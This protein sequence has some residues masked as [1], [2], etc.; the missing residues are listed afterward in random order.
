MFIIYSKPNCAYCVQA[1]NL[2]KSKGLEYLELMLDLGQPKQ[3]DT[4]YVF[5]RDLEKLLP[6]VSSVPQIFER[7][8]G[9]VPATKH[10]GGLKELR[11]RLET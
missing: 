9:A 5:L 3:P 4:E 7:L 2:L 6:G 11:T 1:K 8:G 10:I